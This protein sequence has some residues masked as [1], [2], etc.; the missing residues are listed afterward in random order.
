MLAL[1]NSG[2]LT[3]PRMLHVDDGAASATSI[4][5]GWLGTLPLSSETVLF[6]RNIALDTD[7]DD[8]D[9]EPRHLM[10]HKC[11]LDE[12]PATKLLSRFAHLETLVLFETEVDNFMQTLLALPTTIRHVHSLQQDVDLNTYS[13]GASVVLP[14]LESFTFTWL[15]PPTDSGPQLLA[16]DDLDALA[17]L[18]RRV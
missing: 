6:L 14:R 5:W 12:A 2:G 17:R 10:F 9:L 1:T 13:F 16:D 11:S 7:R 4:K 15:L 18:Q 3:A 8:E